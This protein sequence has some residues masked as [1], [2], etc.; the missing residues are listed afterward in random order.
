MNRKANLCVAVAVV[1]LACTLTNAQVGAQTITVTPANPTISVGQTQ[2]FTATGVGAV[3][4]VDLG[5]FYSC[6][7]LQDGTVRCW[8]DNTTGELGN[9]TTTIASTPAAVA[10][11]AGTPAVPSGL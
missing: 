9:G 10:A 7:L 2:R 1:V 3:T 4:A 6:A 8:G 11:S 5:A